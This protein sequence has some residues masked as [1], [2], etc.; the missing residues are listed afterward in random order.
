MY[1]SRCAAIFP[2][3]ALTAGNFRLLK[4]THAASNSAAQHR[5]GVSKQITGAAVD[6][7][8][9]FQLIWLKNIS[10]PASGKTFKKFTPVLAKNVRSH[11]QAKS[12]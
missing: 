4:I 3:G 8:S 1:S 10:L 6:I 11:A 2:L 5:A 12:N 9:R 7:V